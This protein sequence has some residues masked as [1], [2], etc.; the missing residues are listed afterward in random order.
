MKALKY[1]DIYELGIQILAYPPCLEAYE[2]TLLSVFPSVS[3]QLSVYPPL[4]S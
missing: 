4:V 1:F 2:I 3:L